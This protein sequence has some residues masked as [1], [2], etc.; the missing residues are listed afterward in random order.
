MDT[1]RYALINVNT[2]DNVSIEDFSAPTVSRISFTSSQE[3]A[4]IYVFA[5]VRIRKGCLEQ[6]LNCYRELVPAVQEAES[7]C[8]EYVPTVD[9]PMGLPNQDNDDCRI[10][11]TERWKSLEDFRKHLG[12]SHSA[13]FRTK[14]QPLLAERITVKIVQP[15]LP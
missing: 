15:A 13:A 5:S 4:M 6:A 8:L 9:V 3:V 7:G 11:V 2:Y 10:L 14:I 1:L 12:M